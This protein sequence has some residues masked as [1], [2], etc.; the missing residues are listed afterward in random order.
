MNPNNYTPEIRELI[1]KNILLS[2]GGSIYPRFRDLVFP[3]MDQTGQVTEKSVTSIHFSPS[4]KGGCYI[5]FLHGG[6]Y[7]NEEED[8]Q[9]VW[10][11]ILSNYSFPDGDIA[12]EKEPL[13]RRIAL[14]QRNIVFISRHGDITE[15]DILMAEEYRK[16]MESK[17]EAMKD[18]PVPTPG[19]IVEGAYYGG[20]HPFKDGVIDS[21]PGYKKRF[22]VCAQ[23]YTPFVYLIDGAVPDVAMSVSGGPFFGM[24]EDDL[25]YVGTDT[26]YFCDWGHPGP[27]AD[28][29]VDFPVKVNRWRVK[30]GVDY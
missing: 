18:H 7:V 9:K 13:E 12:L 10:D 20:K 19:D 26:R 30:D 28:G 25:E 2:M 1:A 6:A 11:Y 15:D 23:P 4:D 3:V 21:R 17:R 29:A 5:Y 16:V 27:C 8:K 14:R 22:S 24:N